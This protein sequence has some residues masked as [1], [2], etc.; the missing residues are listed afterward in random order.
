LVPGASRPDEERDVPARLDEAPKPPWAPFPLVEICILVGLVLFVLGVV[1][2][3]SG[4]RRVA[5]LAGG[6]GE[7]LAYTGHEGLAPGSEGWW[8]DGIAHS[9]P[10]GFDLASITIPVMVMH[11]RQDQFVPF[12]HGAWLAAHIPG[13]E[14]RFYDHDGHLTLMANRIGEVHAWLADHF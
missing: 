13:A 14:P 12:G 5:M 2:V 9:T 7:Y 1:G 6:L 11:G 3:A 4:P 10:W 8:D